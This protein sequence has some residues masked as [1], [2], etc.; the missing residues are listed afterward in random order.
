MADKGQK[1]E[2]MRMTKLGW[3]N[4]KK[5]ILVEDI[6]GTEEERN[7][8]YKFVTKAA[9][10]FPSHSYYNCL[11]RVVIFYIPLSSRVRLA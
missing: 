11:V 6:I 7:T 1:S 9:S 2:R 3:E 10:A 4:R 5:V 8:L